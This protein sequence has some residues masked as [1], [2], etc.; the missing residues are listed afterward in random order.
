MKVV[1]LLAAGL[2][3]VGTFAVF[4]YGRGDNPY[5]QPRATAL[6][7]ATA[8]PQV[9]AAPT[10]DGARVAMARAVEREADSR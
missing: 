2:M 8:C 9:G 1:P 10:T 4:A 6:A 3:S 5:A 7:A